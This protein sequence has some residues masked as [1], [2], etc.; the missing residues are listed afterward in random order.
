[1]KLLKDAWKQVGEKIGTK[2]S[3]EEIIWCYRALLGREPESE[4][5]IFEFADLN[6]FKNL[7]GHFTRTPEFLAR[8]GIPADNAATWAVKPQLKML[9]LG[10]CQVVL[11]AKLIE[12]MTFHQVAA[13]SLELAPSVVKQLRSGQINLADLV[14]QYDLV[15]VQTNFTEMR[16]ML[17]QVGPAIQSK[18]RL[19]PG[20]HF[21]AF[22]PD[23]VYVRNGNAGH[24][25]GPLGGYQS[26]IAFYSWL[27]GF[28]I[29]DTVSLFREDVFE[30]L[31]FFDYW[32]SSMTSLVHMGKESS[33][34]LAD[35]LKRWTVH[36]CWMYSTNHPKP[37]VLADIAG[38]MLANEGISVQAG[39]EQFVYDSFA[40]SAV[41]PVYPE[42]G[43]RLGIP[44]HYLFNKPHGKLRGRQAASVI[45]LEEFI[46][47]SFKAFAKGR[48]EDLICERLDSPP[49]KQLRKLLKKSK[50][51]KVA[52]KAE[53]LPLEHTRS[54][55]ETGS[56]PYRNLPDYQFWRRAVERPAMADVDPV[57]RARFTLTPDDKVATAGSCF[58]QHLA[59]ILRRNGFNYYVAE[60][61]PGGLP[62]EEA[63][64]R[65][66]GVFS[67]RYGNV[68]TARQ[69]LQLFDRA[70]G[71]FTP[72]DGAWLRADGR[73]ADP[74]RPQI[75]P[76]GFASL[77]ALQASKSEHLAAV[78]RL[79]ESLDVF[80]F[81][82][83]LT[84]AWQ[85]RVDGAVYPVA[86]GVAAG[87]FD[88]AIHEF[89]NFG[90]AEVAA[91]L[92]AFVERLLSV[93]PKAKMLLTVSPVPLVATYE[94]RHVLA[95]T[96]YSKSVLRTAAEEIAR[97]NPMCDYFP[98][99]EIVTGS[100][101]RGS[102]FED[103]L[104]SV[105]QEG[106]DH[107]MRV[108]VKHYADSAQHRAFVADR[109]AENEQLGKVVCDEE[110]VDAA[111]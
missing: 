37:F 106:V 36:G 26:S 62:A 3:R 86:P 61:A 91:D 52:A 5:A 58:A 10:S 90:P 73:Y 14:A 92:Q 12:A 75:E 39:A 34:E 79:L 42:I 87:S 9:L 97:R 94:D 48:R 7:V 6:N 41:W 99:Y 49:Y 74:F 108:F 1:M 21:A 28:S 67:A 51:G 35:L 25:G 22:H 101:A 103:D 17:E 18:I 4:D 93:N 31:G 104:R 109:L 45:G 44:G 66:F 85:S 88:P 78:R 95:A 30:A 46:R 60:R 84:E 38:A 98:A 64:Q 27:Q 63:K 72:Q 100:Y 105:K 50:P 110:A 102:Y 89:V 13:K 32:D 107:V 15:L 82:L 71:A 56:N 47:G 81:T 59:R 70:Y 83:G 76:D 69:L 20:I 68:Y 23:L 65:N 57:T 96:T 33:V 55:A 54:A 16:Q 11:M 80:V 53:V 24:A 77:E 43:Q 111:P 19:V 2:V 29:A 8:T 40:A